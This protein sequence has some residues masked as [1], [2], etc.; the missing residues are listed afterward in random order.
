MLRAL[1]CL[2]LNPLLWVIINVNDI[3]FVLSKVQYEIN[4][5]R[6]KD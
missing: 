4:G 3:G 1:L 5:C 6:G 2:A